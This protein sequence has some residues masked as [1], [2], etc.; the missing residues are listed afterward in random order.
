MPTF[1]A[2]AYFLASSAGWEDDEGVVQWLITAT[3]LSGEEGP[4]HRMS[5][6]DILDRK[7]SW[8][9]RELETR[10]LLH[11]GEIPL[12][13]AAR[14]LHKTLIELVLFPAIAN[15]AEEDLRRRIM[16]PAY[17][18]KCRSVTIRPAEMTASMDA[19]TLL[20]LGY[21][22]FLDQA[23]G[24]F[25]EIFVPHSTLAWLFDE[26]IRVTFHQP[27][28]IRDAHQLRDLIAKNELGEF[29][30]SV[31]PDSDLA[32]QIG[33]ELASM[34][35][36]A[37][38]VSEYEKTQHL[39]VR[40]APIN[41]L[42][43]LVEEEVDLTDHT[44]VMSSCAHVVEKLKQRGQLTTG[45]A[46]E[47]RSYLQLHEKPW[48]NQPEIADRAVLY[49]DD[50][51]LTYFLHLGILGKI[52]AA[53]LRPFASPRVVSEANALIDYERISNEVEEVIERIRLALSSRIESGSIKVGRRLKTDESAEALLSDHPT[54]DVLGMARSCDIVFSDDRYLNQRDRIADG[55]SPA[56]I[57]STL[58]LL[59]VLVDTGEISM[60]EQLGHRTRLR[61]AGYIFVPVCEKNWL[62]I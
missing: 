62:G 27:S 44:P 22:N 43:S 53:G 47:A 2:N 19:T 4:L 23:L 40:S 48:P 18:G 15:Q 24:A 38:K 54:T 21:L 46:K 33:D 52:S 37:D 25:K 16:I 45:E 17:S 10:R 11:K 7:P 60:D 41:R 1:L 51:A 5:L 26:N 50:L 12:F 57:A 59:D 3:E 42:S 55:D 56:T 14:S 20:T 61:R 31:V 49:L 13:V 36:E 39:V 28:R 8:D 58:D 35:A 32:A 9:R 34:I 6:K 29:I 30:A